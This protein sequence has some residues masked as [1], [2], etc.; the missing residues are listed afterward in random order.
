MKLITLT[1]K[2]I[3]PYC[4]CRQEYPAKDYFAPQTIFS[5][6]IQCDECDQYF[7]ARIVDNKVEVYTNALRK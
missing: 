3:C 6:D 4:H 5:D 2:L 1:S 7:N